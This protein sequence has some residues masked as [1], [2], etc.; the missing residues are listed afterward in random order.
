MRLQDVTVKTLMLPR[1]GQD[2]FELHQNRLA[3]AATKINTVGLLG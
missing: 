3:H 2:A 1:E